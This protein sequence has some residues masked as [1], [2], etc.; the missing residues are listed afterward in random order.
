M[1]PLTQNPKIV[2]LV[3]SNGIVV[4]TATNVAPDLNVVVTT[5]EVAFEVEASN[6]PFVK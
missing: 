2:L 6:Q 4:K 5:S 1:T 3:D